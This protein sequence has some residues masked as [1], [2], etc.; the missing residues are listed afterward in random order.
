MDE[1]PRLSLEELALPEPRAGVP[2]A[3]SEDVHAEDILTENRVPLTAEGLQLALDSGIELLQAAAARVAGAHGERAVIG[4]VRA[5]LG[6]I[7]DTDRAAAAYALARLGEPDGIEAL[8]ALL[9]LPIDAY[10]A[11]VQA[12]G[13]LARLGDERGLEVVERALRSPNEIVRAV[14]T[15]QLAFFGERGRELLERALGDSDPEIARQ[16]RILLDEE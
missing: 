3:D 8:V 12:A 1:L 15:K 2:F 13:S 6:G 5:L 4:S 7:G 10:V 14:A 11:P 16:A 9:E